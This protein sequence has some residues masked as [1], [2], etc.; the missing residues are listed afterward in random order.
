MSTYQII[1]KE[2]TK[3]VERGTFMHNTQML[4]VMGVFTALMNEDL[5]KDKILSN[6]QMKNDIQ[7]TDA[8]MFLKSISPKP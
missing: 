1:K 5:V 4:L 2:L 8:L 7:M 3:G 6:D